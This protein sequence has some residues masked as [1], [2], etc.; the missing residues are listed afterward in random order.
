MATAAIEQS[1]LAKALPSLGAVQATLA[2]RSL[3]DFFRLSWPVLEPAT[4]LIWNWHLQAIC[5]HVQALLEGRIPSNNLAI[6]VP[7]GSSKS[8]IV[9]VCAPAWWW[10][11]H[12]EWRAIFTSRNPRAVVRDSIYCRTLIQSK[13]YQES[14]IQ[15]KPSEDRW[16]LTGDQNAKQL[17]ANTRGGF[18]QAIGA[19]SAVTGDRANGLFM[20]DML[21]AA[22]GESKAAREEFIT[23]YDQAFAN[24]VSDMATSTRCIIGQRLHQSDPVGHLLK[25]GHWELLKIRQNFELEREQGAPPDTPKVRAKPTALGWTDPRTTEGELMDPVRFPADKLA[26]EK[27]RLGTR[28]YAAQHGQDP[29]PAEGSILSRS[30]FKFYRT[31]RDASGNMLPPAQIIA[32]LGIQRIVQAA[33][34]ALGE[35][36]ANDWT[37]DITMGETPTRIYV[38]DLLKAKMSAPTMKSNLIAMHAKWNAH[39]LVIEGGSSASGKAAAQ[40][41]KAETS[42]PVI[43]LMVM[44]DKV[45]G[46]NAIAP[47]VEA[48]VVYL[49]EDQPWAMD[50]IES[51]LAF[52]AGANDDDCDAFRICIWYL[53]FGGAGMG[54]FEHMR[55]MAAAAAPQTPQNGSTPPAVHAPPALLAAMNGGKNGNGNGT[56]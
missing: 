47:T 15:T 18:R 17:Y 43:E 46:M 55:R 35:K 30:W 56:H 45:V 34:T 49:P 8:R 28:G 10:I 33:D 54:L 24:R 14:F 44:H 5:D 31:P 29:Y 52:P 20:D 39:G 41:I 36:Q 48:G 40:T 27:T 11:D 32:A 16:R 42:L 38:L 4:K 12:P 9:S 51:L 19:G 2:R 21:D 25:S 7:P 53:K 3:A 22:E 50:L 23:W 26:E 37:A 1:P 13:W 6:T